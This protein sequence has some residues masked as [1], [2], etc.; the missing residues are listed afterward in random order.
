MDTLRRQPGDGKTQ[1][2]KSNAMSLL[3]EETGLVQT[4]PSQRRLKVLHV[5]PTFHP[6]VGGIETMIDEL[7]DH[8][9][10][11]HTDSEIAHISVSHKRLRDETI[12]GKRIYRIPLFGSRLL[13]LAPHLR[14][15]VRG[16]DLIHVHDPHLMAITANVILFA[17]AQPV[18]LSTHGG[19]H[20]TKNL[21]LW[22]KLHEK[23]A[24]RSM[25]K[26]YTTILASSAAD[27]QH[28]SKFSE[29]VV[30]CPNGVNVDRFQLP[31]RRQARADRWIY[32]GRFSVNKRLDRIIACVAQARRAGF[33]VDLCICGPDFDGISDDLRNQIAIEG[34]NGCVE[35]KPFLPIEALKEELATRTVFITASEHEGFGLSIVEA[36]AAGCLIVCRDMAPLND[37]V[38]QGVNGMFLQF[39]GGDQ[40]RTRLIKFLQMEEA[41]LEYSS[42]NSMMR[43]ALHSWQGVV[44]AF[45]FAYQAALAK[46]SPHS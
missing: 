44:P 42:N 18:V 10:L 9:R 39:D 43:A 41:A 13:G 17:R 4:L 16:F 15:I 34:L 12:S 28:F 23:L 32:W 6:E 29:R 24:L 14:N 8:L 33:E 31:K 27:Y 1:A 46:A 3:V 37:F 30:L 19:Y 36:M 2:K 11:Y 20:H 22:K 40:D 7:T 5:T 45:A 35:L 21:G 25:L 26:A 38:Q